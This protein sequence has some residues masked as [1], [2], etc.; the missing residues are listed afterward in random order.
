M[1]LG[2]IE[3]GGTKFVCAVGDAS[4]K[5]LATERI[6]TETPEITMEKVIKF[7]MNFKIEALGIATFGPVDLDP[8]SGT[9]G[10]ITSTPKQGWANYPLLKTMKKK[11]SLPVGITTDVNG[12]ALGE[13]YRGAGKG[14]NGC[15]YLTVGTGIGG[16]AI[17][18]G[19]VLQGMSHPEMGHIL[20]R[21]HPNDQEFEGICPY[22]KDCLEGLASG[23]ALQARWGKPARALPSDHSAWEIEADYLAQALMQY[24]LIVSPKRIILGGGVMKQAQLFPLI[25][26]KLRLYL[27]NYVAFPELNADIDAY[28]VPPA[29]GDNAG[30][31]GALILAKQSLVK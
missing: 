22:H 17:S 7:F 29:L 30:I 9:Y 12:A 2:A 11:L 31:T 23:P 3:A 6:A 21:R 8:E 19:H 24:V 10:T 18:E 20:L 5:I 13:L 25:R 1:Y 15:L 4:G 26:E 27:N 28:V 14:L 16:G